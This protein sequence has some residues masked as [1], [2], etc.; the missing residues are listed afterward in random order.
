MLLGRIDAGKKEVEAAVKLDPGNVKARLILG[1][2]HLKNND[3]VAA[4]K[5][6]VEVLRRNPANF[7]AAVLY[8][9][10]FLLRKEWKKAE[11]VYTMLIRQMPKSP[12]GYFKMGLSSK[13]QNK[14]AEAARYFSQAVERNPGNLAAV[15]EFI[16]ALAASGKVDKARG[17]LEGYLE[18][19]PKNPLLWEMAG[20]FHLA[21]EKPVEAESAFLKAVE[22][23]PESPQSL[24]ELGVLYASQKRFPEAEEKLKKVVEK[25]GK[26]VAAHTMLGVVLQSQGRIKDANR[27]YR[28]ALEIDPK[29]ALAANNLASNL[30]DHGGDLNEAIKYAKIALDAAPN[31]PN[32]GDTLGWLYYKKG[33]FDSASPLISE[34]ARKLEKNAVVR[35]HHGMVLAKQGRSREAAQ[36]LNAALSLDPDFPEAGEARKILENLK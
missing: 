35:Y 33:L 3:P 13:M 24:Y 6:A 1:E 32:V 19:E 9:D 20:R 36:E 8:G 18:K 17:V 14:P 16:F 26:N 30:A 21:S 28:R 31:N 2:L 11:Q 5:E 4:E 25:D 23:A 10:A 15:N 27:H 29:N 34:A 12:I 7:Q 22:L